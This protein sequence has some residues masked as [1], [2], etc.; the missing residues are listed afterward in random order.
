MWFAPI[1]LDDFNFTSGNLVLKPSK[2]SQEV[3]C[4]AY[5]LASK[6]VS[7]RILQSLSPNCHSTCYS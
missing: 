1:P 4:R 6:R 7:A 5:W 3:R 2:E